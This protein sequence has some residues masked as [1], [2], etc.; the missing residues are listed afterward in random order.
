MSTDKPKN[1]G[2][3]LFREAK[4]YGSG[5]A[6]VPRDK[7]R[8]FRVFQRA[9]EA[10]NIKGT[11]GLALAYFEGNG[12]VRD[13]VVAESLVTP[14]VPEVERRAEDGDPDYQLILG[15]MYSFG[16]GKPQDH[17]RAFSLYSQAAEAGNLEAQCNLGYD[18]LV[19][20]GV[21]PDIRMTIHW[22]SKSAE[23]GYAH[24]CRDLGDCYLRGLGVPR[25]P[26]RAIEWLRK[27]SDSNYSH[28]TSDLA[29]CYL[30]GIGVERDRERAMALYQLAYAQ[31]RDRTHRDLLAANIDVDLFL[32]EGVIVV[33]EVRS[34]T[35]VP[36]SECRSGR[37][38]V[39]SSVEDLDPGAFTPRENVFK[40]LVDNQ[41]QKFSVVDGVLYSH[42]RKEIIRY[43][44]GRDAESFVVPPFV[45]SIGRKAFQN[46]RRLLRV[47]LNDGIRE[48][49]DSAFDDCKQILEVGLPPTLETIGP[50]AFHG[51]DALKELHLPASLRQVGEYAFGSCEALE[52]IHI[53][54]GNADFTSLDGVLFDK[55]RSQLLQYPIGCSA[56]QYQVPDS[57]QCIRF[58]AFSDAY[59]L[60][61]VVL[62]D[63]V[64]EIGD[65]VFYFATHLTRVHLLGPPVAILGR[66]VFDQTHPDLI[67]LVPARWLHAYKADER[68]RGLNFRPE[69]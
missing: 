8:S 49:G 53:D 31:D 9:H 2:E 64:A 3:I 67:L 28:G 52:R 23:A 40:F 30:R 1:D 22:W 33:R 20:Q 38:F 45:R 42:D 50:W 58:R 18:Y 10:G 41:S 26:E 24:S 48:I 69:E 25:D 56:R 19:G 13:K 35:R 57:V 39:R 15:D 37:Y 5:S 65:K 7:E 43:P 21:D 17:V 11:F 68:F 59:H 34:V 60:E 27:A 51:C 61:D 63:Q 66:Q 62:G 54:S 12:V 46:A 47:W 6:R 14:V 44:N 16:L 32:E 36:E 29:Y 4:E 55:G